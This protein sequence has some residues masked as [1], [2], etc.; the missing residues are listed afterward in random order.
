MYKFLF[1]CISFI[2]NDAHLQNTVKK[3]IL[4]I[5]NLKTKIYDQK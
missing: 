2:C 1:P 5:I 4:V 3:Y